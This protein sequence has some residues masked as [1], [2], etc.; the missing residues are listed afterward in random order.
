MNPNL[1]TAATA[2]AMSRTTTPQAAAFEAVPAENL[3]WAA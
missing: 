3:I 2:P 1:F